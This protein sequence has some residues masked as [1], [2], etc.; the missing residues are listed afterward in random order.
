[1][2]LTADELAGI[3]DLFGAV[4][5]DEL[6]RALD[7]LAARTGESALADAAA[8]ETALESFTLLAYEVDGEPGYAVGPTSFPTLPPHAEDLPHI[9]DVPHRSP[10]AAE[11]GRVAGER[12]ADEVADAIA[13][14]DTERA[15]E[16]LDLSYDVEAWAPVELSDERSRLDE[17]TS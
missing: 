17:L 1:M 9:L 7:E 14:D 4:T 16:L 2:D 12:F 5:D 13:A 10:D 11:L 8:I 15:R 3:V 6:G